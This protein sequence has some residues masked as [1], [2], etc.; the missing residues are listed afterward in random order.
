MY[1]P[2]NCFPQLYMGHANLITIFLCFKF[3]FQIFI[4]NPNQ[5]DQTFH[6]YIPM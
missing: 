6:M 5:L 1:L 4:V 3:E 2:C